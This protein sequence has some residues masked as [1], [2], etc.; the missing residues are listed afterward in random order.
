MIA[1]LSFL[2]AL[3]AAPMA[4]AQETPPPVAAAT[5]AQ[6]AEASGIADQLIAEAGA[7]G[8]FV[9]KTDSAAP[10]VMHLG[11]GMRCTFDGSGDRV[12]VGS[13]GSPTISA[14]IAPDSISRVRSAISS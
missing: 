10:T 7:A 4:L 14:S 13:D 3:L 8:I 9:N 6:I 1:R 2:A 11:S 12:V 5:P